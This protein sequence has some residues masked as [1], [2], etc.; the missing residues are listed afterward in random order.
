M[1][2]KQAQLEFIKLFSSAVPLRE[3]IDFY[4]ANQYISNWFFKFLFLFVNFVCCITLRTSTNPQIETVSNNNTPSGDSPA[5]PLTASPAE[6]QPEQLPIAA[7]E[8]V[9]SE[10]PAELARIEAE[11]EQVNQMHLYYIYHLNS[12]LIITN[13][14]MFNNYGCHAILT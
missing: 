4:L 2:K 13:N 11:R 7:S 10:D 3:N 12:I 14:C 9:N 8:P 6:S 1:S 5:P